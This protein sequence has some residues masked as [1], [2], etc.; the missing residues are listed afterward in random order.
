M[1]NPEGRSNLSQ[2][3]AVKQR[4]ESSD[5]ESSDHVID[6]CPDSLQGEEGPA[7]SNPAAEP[8]EPTAAAPKE[9]TADTKEADGPEEAPGR[10]GEGEGDG[11]NS[12]ADTVVKTAPGDAPTEQP[13]EHS[14]NV[15]S[16]EGKKKANKK[17]AETTEP[18]L[19]LNANVERA[20]RT[21]Q[22]G[23][24]ESNQETTEQK[25]AVGCETPSQVTPMNAHEAPRRRQ[26]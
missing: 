17:A 20:G 14:K 25:V 1:V 2:E 12:C 6:D 15:M 22:T 5:S 10:P 23:T 7:E 11:P 18:V 24:N 26:G 13:L 3:Q 16:G 4:T 19:D 9:Q 8:S 21:N